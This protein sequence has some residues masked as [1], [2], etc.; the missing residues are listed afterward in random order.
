MKEIDFYAIASKR[1]IPSYQY[2]CYQLSD[3]HAIFKDIAKFDA[4]YG[5]KVVDFTLAQPE[6]GQKNQ[7]QIVFGVRLTKKDNW[8]KAEYKIALEDLYFLPASH[9]IIRYSSCD[10]ISCHPEILQNLQATFRFVGKPDKM[11]LE[12]LT[13][14]ITDLSLGAKNFVPA[15]PKH[16][17]SKYF[18]RYQTLCRQKKNTES[19][20]WVLNKSQEYIIHAHYVEQYYKTGCGMELFFDEQLAA[21]KRLLENRDYPYHNKLRVNFYKVNKEKISCRADAEFFIPLKKLL[22]YA[23]NLAPTKATEPYADTCFK[24]AQRYLFLHKKEKAKFIAS[25]TEF[26]YQR[27]LQPYFK[28]TFWLTRSGRQGHQKANDRVV[29]LVHAKFLK[30]PLVKELLRQRIITEDYIK[31]FNPLGLNEII[32]T[33]NKSPAAFIIFLAQTAKL[34]HVDPSIKLCLPNNIFSGSSLV[35]IDEFIKK[36][37]EAVFQALICPEIHEYI[38]AQGITLE[39]LKSYSQGAIEELFSRA[40]QVVENSPNLISH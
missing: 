29:A 31:V 16:G 36:I 38:A 39:K 12:D 30:E 21:A 8:D 13:R 20:A 33:L 27:M 35:D 2:L 5:D 17:A 28:Y 19:L 26:N 6:A 24:I 14:L 25:A 18:E 34:G 23:N 40:K 3:I 11:S 37:P 9:F 32:T 15:L 10:A 1:N 22:T 4:S 7:H